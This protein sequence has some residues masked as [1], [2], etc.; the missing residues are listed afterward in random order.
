MNK[1]AQQIDSVDGSDAVPTGLT[2][3][4]KH[5]ASWLKKIP[6]DALGFGENFVAQFLFSV[7][8]LLVKIAGK[9]MGS[10]ELIFARSSVQIVLGSLWV[11]I[12]SRSS[13]LYFTFK[14]F[15]KQNWAVLA[16]LFT[17]GFIGIVAMSGWF[18]S[19]QFLT[20][21]DATLV[22]FLEPIFTAL[23][24]RIILKEKLS[25]VEIVGMVL[26]L[27]GILLVARPPIIFEK[28]GFVEN[29]PL[30]T[31]TSSALSPSLSSSSSLID[32]VMGM[33]AWKKRMIG[34]LCGIESTFFAGLAYILTRVLGKRGVSSFVVVNWLSL[35][36]LMMTPLPAFFLENKVVVPEGWEWAILL[37]IGVTA[38]V[39]QTGLTI[40]L[41]TGHAARVVIANY[42]TIV[43]GFLFGVL[44]LGE[45]ISYLSIAGAVLIS[46]NALIAIWKGWRATKKEHSQP[47]T[48]KV[49]QSPDPFDFFEKAI[50][51]DI[52]KE[53]K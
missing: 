38:T 36:G 40:A 34:I 50:S 51:D 31:A 10:F 28:L 9:R 11:S 6:V 21:G 20:L 32:A 16:L 15:K 33:D 46:S 45:S 49:H 43:W 23:F 53:E 1:E 41:Q 52:P 3:T 19:I 30:N 14:G 8:A 4:K 5:W 27:F 47:S 29:I 17:R 22:S 25:V 42:M 37:A 39:A 7:M 24:G 26:S 48:T 12:H 44:V 2:S 18:L 13:P 35:C